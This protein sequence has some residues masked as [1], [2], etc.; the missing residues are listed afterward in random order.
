MDI[1]MNLRYSIYIYVYIRVWIYISHWDSE[2]CH[3]WNEHIYTTR[4]DFQHPYYR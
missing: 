4:E 2:Y 1:K 3:Y